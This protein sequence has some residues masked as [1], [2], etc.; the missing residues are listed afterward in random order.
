M[1]LEPKRLL[2]TTPGGPRLEFTGRYECRRPV[3]RLVE[4]YAACYPDDN[5][6]IVKIEIEEGFETDGASTPFF[7]W[8]IIPPLDEETLEAV[9][10][11]DKICKSSS[12][13]RRVA[14]ALLVVFLVKSR[15][16]RW[17]RHAL[18]YACRFY[19]AFVRPLRRAVGGSD[20]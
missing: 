2:G 18:Y 16:R 10:V 7:V 11:H 17:K 5:D 20:G 6:P 19:A 1:Q 8:P 3:Y 14:E 9:L 15:C 4:A 12:V 13:P